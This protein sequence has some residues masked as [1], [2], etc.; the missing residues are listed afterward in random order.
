MCPTHSRQQS[1]DHEAVWSQ[2]V[3]LE[4]LEADITDELT[5]GEQ[6]D[7]QAVGS[8]GND[9]YGDD[10]VVVVDEMDEMV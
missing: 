6:V 7:G 10:E 9:E 8:L 1:E 4:V 5:E 3:E 2:L